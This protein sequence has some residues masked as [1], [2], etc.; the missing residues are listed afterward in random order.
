VDWYVDTLV[1]ALSE[2]DFRQAYERGDGLCL[3]HLRLALAASEAT[4]N[5]ETARFLSQLALDRLRKLR[6]D[7]AAY[8]RKQSYEHR[9]EPI[10]EAEARSWIRAVAFMVGEEPR[11]TAMNSPLRENGNPASK[12][13][14]TGERT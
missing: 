7:L 3:P 6:D 10:G 8:L 13:A 4:H 11:L 2:P 12:E 1:R 14:R 5:L 9:H